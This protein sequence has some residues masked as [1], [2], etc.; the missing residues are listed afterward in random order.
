MAPREFRKR[1]QKMRNTC[2]AGMRL[3]KQ[4]FRT[5]LFLRNKAPS[6]IKSAPI[7]RLSCSSS[8]WRSTHCCFWIDQTICKRKCPG[9]KSGANGS[10]IMTIR[11]MGRN[12]MTLTMPLRLGSVHLCRAKNSQTLPVYRRQRHVNLSRMGITNYCPHGDY[13]CRSSCN[14]HNLCKGSISWLALHKQS[15]QAGR[16]Q[17][18]ARLFFEQATISTWQLVWAEQNLIYDFT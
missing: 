9:Q 2:P 5:N 3:K 4:L 6:L 14:Q 12:T 17:K 18:I 13:G 8:T 7:R 11:L 1:L 16:R 15:W 10:Y